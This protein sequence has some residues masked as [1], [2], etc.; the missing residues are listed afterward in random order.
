VGHP[1]TVYGKGGQTRGFLDIRDTVRCI[2]VGDGT[3]GGTTSGTV[4]SGAAVLHCCAGSPPPAAASTRPG[5][6][7]AQLAAGGQRGVSSHA[8]TNGCKPGIDGPRV[9]P[10]HQCYRG[11][12]QPDACRLCMP[13][14]AIDNPAEKGT[15]RVFNQFTE[16][17]RSGP[18]CLVFPCGCTGACGVFARQ[19]LLS[20]R[21]CPTARMLPVSRGVYA[22]LEGRRL[23]MDSTLV[24]EPD[25]GCSPR[26]RLQCERSGPHRHRRGQEA[27]AGGGGELAAL[28]WQR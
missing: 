6:R 20:R 9:Q 17:F 10:S 15:M 24:M 12:S 22:L 16:Q 18:R 13:Q 26:A 19:R 11:S 23:L 28:S 21:G 25:Q 27:G 4:G 8:G 7:P 14:I 5:A 1:L 3:V 2:Q